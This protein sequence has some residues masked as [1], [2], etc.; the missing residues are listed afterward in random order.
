RHASTAFGY[1]FSA[2]STLSFDA[3]DNGEMAKDG[4][5]TILTYCQKQRSGMTLD[6]WAGDGVAFYGQRWGTGSGVTKSSVL[7]HPTDKRALPIA[8]SPYT[9]SDDAGGP[10][11]VVN[12]AFLTK[13]HACDLQ[14]FVPMPY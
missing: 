14:S 13:T 7:R 8:I 1:A 3:A 12:V 2:R 11:A 4:N 10:F 6:G 5:Q 9:A